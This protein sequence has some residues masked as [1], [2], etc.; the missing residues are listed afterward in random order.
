MEEMNKLS[1]FTQIM[2]IL[3]TEY[4]ISIV[5][6]HFIGKLRSSLKIKLFPEKNISRI[7]VCFYQH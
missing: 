7:A 2:L 4:Y 3:L 5:I 6:T 1:T